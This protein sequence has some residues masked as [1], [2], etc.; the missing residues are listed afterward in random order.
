[1]KS[2]AGLFAGMK[3]L[4]ALSPGRVGVLLCAFWRDW[5]V[6]PLKRLR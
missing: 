5:G 4:V 2:V 3:G 6:V 1:M